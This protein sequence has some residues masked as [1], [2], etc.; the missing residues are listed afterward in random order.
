MNQAILKPEVQNFLRDHIQASP[1]SIALG[2]SPFPDVSAPELAE[3]LDGMKRAQ[4]KLPQWF[5][6]TNI[7]YPG[8]LG[9]EQSSS[10]LTG[11][12]KRGL[13]NVGS[14]IVDI[15]GG[16][17][18]D[19]YYFAQR[20]QKVIHCERNAS[21]S[22]IAEHNAKQL[23]VMNIQFFPND[24]IGY[25]HSSDKVF[26]FIYIDPSRRVKQQKVFRLSD[27]E[28]DVVMH[29]PLLKQRGKTVLIKAAPLLDIQAAVHELSGVT[30]V[31]IISA[32]NE[33]KELLF[34]LRNNPTNAITFHCVALSNK[35]SD[36]LRFNEEQEKTSQPVFDNPRR[37]LYEPDAALLK[38]GCF[39]YTAVH[40]N[41]SKLH[42]HTHLYTSE[43][44]K[45]GFIG[46]CFEV[47][48]VETYSDFKKNKNST[49]GNVS[50]R[51]F[52][53]KPQELK[54]KH[55]IKDGGDQYLFFCTG[56]QEQLLVLFCRKHR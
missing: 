7:Y 41:L 32:H 16:F 36:I 10:S 42:Q 37:Y 39:K 3:Q 28:P 29:G 40:F 35:T 43:T 19:D 44:F 14:S 13:I 20:A 23:G 50:T 12:Y 48:K 2:K 51:N 26:D 18:V 22:R 38:A 9:L 49:Q 8:L 5:N 30:D 17:G 24:G 21:L 25:L 56:P 52:P 34:V 53:L 1:A 33:C 31:H 54:K 47:I 45:E 46:R 27:C 15:T 4:K 6:T 11:A 55:K